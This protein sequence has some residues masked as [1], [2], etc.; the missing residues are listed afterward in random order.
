MAG[1]R[2]PSEPRSPAYGCR[3]SEG[4]ERMIAEP[5][6]R[7]VTQLMFEAFLRVSKRK[8]AEKFAVGGRKKLGE[9]RS[10]KSWH[11]C[12]RIPGEYWNYWAR[13]WLEARLLWRAGWFRRR[14]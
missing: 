2:Q 3:R 8:L 1:E 6:D 11:V 13:E 10:V 9:R 5:S 12:A 4:S 14:G 7:G